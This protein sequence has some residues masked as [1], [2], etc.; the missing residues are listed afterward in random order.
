MSLPDST[1]QPSL[2][3]CGKDKITIMLLRKSGKTIPL[4]LI[5]NQLLVLMA[6]L[7]RTNK[8]KRGQISRF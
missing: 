7:V 3:P 8:K 6:L 4:F 1:S 2:P 5:E